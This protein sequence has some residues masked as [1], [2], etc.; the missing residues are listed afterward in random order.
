MNRYPYKF[1]TMVEESN[2]LPNLK[3]SPRGVLL[4]IQKASTEHLNVLGLNYE[5]LKNEG[6]V[7]MVVSSATKF[8]YTPCAY[9]EIYVA[10]CPA[11]SKGAQMIRETCLFS[12]KGEKLVENQTAWIMMNPESGR[13]L[14]PNEFN[15]ELPLL[16]NWHPF[17]EPQ[18]IRIPI[19]EKN[20][21]ER[22]VRLSDLDRNLHMNNTIYAS[23]LTDCFAEDVL[24]GEPDT[25][26]I[27]YK[28]Q[29]KLN[30]VLSLRGEKIENQYILTAADGENMCFQGMFTLRNSKNKV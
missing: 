9:D 25:L 17:F 5:T 14:K 4:Y 2:C 13:I 29:A 30:H 10:T 28:N 16:E 23:I 26:F 3:I 27:K 24:A 8:F 15:H 21:G 11:I 7:F 12:A 1:K 19:S 20:L 18:K 22:K 6:I